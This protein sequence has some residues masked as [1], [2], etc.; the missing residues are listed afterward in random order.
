MKNPPIAQLLEKA[1]A[2]RQS[3]FDEC[4]QAA[5]RL[6]NGFSEGW[7]ALVIDLYAATVVVHNYAPRPVDGAAAVGVAQEII[8]ERLPWVHTLIVKVRNGTAD[9]RRGR[10]VSGPGPDCK[11]REHGVWYALDLLMHQDTS[12]Y[13]DTRNLRKWAIENLKDKTILNT[14]AYT[15]SLG[16]AAMAGGARRV[17]QI[18]RN[19]TFLNLAKTSYTLNGF[20]IDKQDFQSGDFWPHVNRLKRAGETFDCVF[21]DPPFFAATPGGRVDLAAN[22][23]RLI[24]KVRPLVTD[25]GWLVAVNNALFLSGRE[26]MTTLEALCAGGYLQIEALIPVPEDFSGYPKTQA[27]GPTVDP[28]PF[29]HPTKIALLRVKHKS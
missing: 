8:R 9:D 26:Y 27:G 22:S 12:L 2:A 4:H 1:I 24:N 19:R 11:A 3:L 23:P 20:P 5:L 7:P 29:N 18:D 6:F 13:L 17:V 14:F 25:D 15:G 10:I 28:A 16:V 21:L